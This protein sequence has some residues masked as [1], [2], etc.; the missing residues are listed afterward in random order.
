MDAWERVW[1]VVGGTITAVAM[2]A[3]GYLILSA[4]I[5]ET[6]WTFTRVDTEHVCRAGQRGD[7]L[8]RTPGLVKSI[9]ELGFTLEI[10]RA[11]YRRH[12]TSLDG[13]QPAVGTRVVTEDWHGR[14]VSVFDPSMGRRHTN[15]WPSWTKDGFEA[16]AAWAAVLFIPVVV[17]ISWLG[18]WRKR[19]RS[20]SA[21]MSPLPP[22]PAQP[23]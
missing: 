12:V 22:E 18:D 21:G 7:C 3:F 9:D 10:D 11:P 19:R 13:L 2:L 6:R 15:Q 1:A 14:L 8:L 5:N 17:A 23:S 16:L 4:A 20:R